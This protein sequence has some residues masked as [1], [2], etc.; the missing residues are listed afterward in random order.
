MLSGK[1]CIVTGSTAGIGQAIARSLLQEGAF[2]FVNGRSTESVQKAIDAFNAEGLINTHGVAADVSTAD[3]CESFFEQVDATG[4]VVD[5]LVNNTGIFSAADF[6][7]VSDEVWAQYFNVN[8]LSGV[9]MCRKYLKP[10]LERNQGRIILI[11]S[12]AGIRAIPDMLHY[13]TTKA[14]VINLARGLAELTKGTNVTV[15]SVLPGPTATE[16]VKVFIQGL[17]EASGK[18]E[19]ETV[20]DF[21]KT[22]EPTSLA[23]RFLKPEEIAD[24]VTFLAS[25]KS[26]GINGATQR[27]EGGIIRSL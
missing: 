13:S 3:G 17:M 27:V 25:P 9:R 19:D 23:Q 24:V 22:R 15:N 18:S 6:F 2:V 1:N 26:S 16:G 5:V 7:D 20:R 4:R 11:S 14:T 10:M 12:E 21:F 8:V